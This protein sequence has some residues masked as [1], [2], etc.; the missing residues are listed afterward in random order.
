MISKATPSTII[1]TRSQVGNRGLTGGVGSG[2]TGLPPPT[3]K[4]LNTLRKY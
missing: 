2:G 3:L 4:S 1:K